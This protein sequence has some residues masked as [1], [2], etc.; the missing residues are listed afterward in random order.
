MSN[1]SVMALSQ[2]S[3][4]IVPRGHE[5]FPNGKYLRGWRRGE[6]PALESPAPQGLSLA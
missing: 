5:L 2:M 6:P 3:S 4:F 1:G